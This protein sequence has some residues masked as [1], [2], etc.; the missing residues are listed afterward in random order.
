L[1]KRR[2]KEKVRS[3]GDGIREERKTRAV[4]LLESWI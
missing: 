1:G 3:I 2:V 4:F